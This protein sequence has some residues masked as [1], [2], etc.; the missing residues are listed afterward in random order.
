[1]AYDRKIR[2]R[3]TAKVMNAL[4]NYD[5]PGNVRE[6]QNALY[7]FVTI[8]RLDLSG[9]AFA[10]A[11]GAVARAEAPTG[12]TAHRLSLNG[13]VAAFEKRQI[14][15]ALAECHWNRTRTAK[16]LGIGLRTLQRKMKTYGVQ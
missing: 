6:L 8:K 16:A 11:G 2:P 3:I 5:W 10:G 14:T 9:D 7:R 12:E 15:S 1:M 13:A 4:M